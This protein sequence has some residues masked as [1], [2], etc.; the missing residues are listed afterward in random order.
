MIWGNLIII[1][2]KQEAA[3]AANIQNQLT[4]M[5][6]EQ[7]DSFLDKFKDLT[8]CKPSVQYINCLQIIFLQRYYLCINYYMLQTDGCKQPLILCISI[9]Q[10]SSDIMKLPRISWATSN[11]CKVAKFAWP[12]Y[13]SQFTSPTWNCGFWLS[14]SFTFLLLA[15]FGS[16]RF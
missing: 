12:R 1:L 9:L 11:S 4:E 15:P 14:F 6:E 10:I 5:G 16:F 3:L 2:L 13:F 8:L 7:E